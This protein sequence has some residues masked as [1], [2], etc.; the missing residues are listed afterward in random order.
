MKN[1]INKHKTDLILYFGYILILIVLIT[2]AVLPQ[3]RGAVSANK[4]YNSTAIGFGDSFGIQWYAVFIL[5]GIILATFMALTE[6]KRFGWVSDDII[7]GVLII[8]P[9]AILGARLYYVLFDPYGRPDSFMDVIAIWEGGL[10]IH[11]A[12]IVAAIGVIIYSRYKKLNPFALAD[13]LA[14]G[15]LIG[16]ISGRWGNFMNAEAHG[17]AT[18]SSFLM[19]ILPNFITHQMHFSSHMTNLVDSIYLPTFLFESLWNFIG[20]T[21]L[22]VLRRTKLLK[23]GDLLGIYLI[24]YGFGRGVLIEPFRTDQLKPILGVPVNILLSLILFVGGGIVYLILKRVFRKDEK[25]YYEI[26]INDI[27][28]FEKK[29]K[30]QD[31]KS[32]NI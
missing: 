11:G 13:L 25:Y 14:V 19:G 2:L 26:L 28:L 9:L 7:D 1:W 10:A 6:I 15:L 3:Y 24:W 27:D 5:T 32:D 21:L 30:Q 22:L 20:L 31:D 12:I 16:Q 17:A 8:A 18:N 4:A 23:I 29:A